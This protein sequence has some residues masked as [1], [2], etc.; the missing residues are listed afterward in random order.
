MDAHRALGY[1]ASHSLRL[2]GAKCFPFTRRFREGAD[3]DAA[4]ARRTVEG[5]A[6]ASEEKSA[7]I[8]THAIIQRGALSGSATRAPSRA[9]AP[10]PRRPTR[11]R[12]VFHARMTENQQIGREKYWRFTALAH[13][14]ARRATGRRARGA[15]ATTVASRCGRAS[16]SREATPASRRRRAGRGRRCGGDD[17]RG[18]AAL[19]SPFGCGD[20]DDVDERLITCWPRRRRPP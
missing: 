16:G 19:P 11:S 18:T 14:P 7:P 10:L 8:D 9:R 2:G 15:R 3:G 4:G 5:L 1:R 12:R 17:E 20:D 6:R 13:S